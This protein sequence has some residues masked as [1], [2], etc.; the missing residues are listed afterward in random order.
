WTHGDLSSWN[1]LGQPD[2]RLTVLDWETANPS[3]VPLLDVFHFL[4]FERILLGEKADTLIGR[5]LKDSSVVGWARR[6]VGADRQTASALL[7]VYLVDL[8][9][10]F[11]AS[12]E[13][14]TRQRAVALMLEES[15]EV[16]G[17]CLSR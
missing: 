2:G 8:L 16:L 13:L 3:G 1:L 12:S 9:R 14:G 5:C 6:C 17:D 15:L 11:R 4:V 7:V 10:L